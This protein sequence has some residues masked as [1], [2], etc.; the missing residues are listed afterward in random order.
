MSACIAKFNIWGFFLIQN[1]M[2][3]V[4]ERFKEIQL[5]CLNTINKQ[6]HQVIIMLDRMTII[7]SK[8]FIVLYSV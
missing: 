1:L 2:Y 8:L 6:H 3:L 7:L 4:E 5:C